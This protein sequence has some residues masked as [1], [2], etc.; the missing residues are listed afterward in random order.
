MASPPT[1]PPHEPTAT[2]A[3]L[4]GDVIQSRKH[5]DQI[6]LLETL[7]GLLERVNSV[8]ALRQPLAMTTGDGFQGFSTTLEDALR[9]TT[10]LHLAC[11]P[12]LDLRL[13]L[14]WG[15]IVIRDAVQVPVGQSGQAWWRARDAIELVASQVAKQKWP[16]S[17]RTWFIGDTP[18]RTAATNA[19]LICRDQILA[20]M[21]PS[22]R[23][24]AWGLFQS[25]R[26]ITL[27][28]DLAMTQPQISKHQKENGPAALFQAHAALED[29]LR[30]EATR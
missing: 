9:V 6:L 26:Q 19:F 1:S 29:G 23:R 14:G 13:G 4:I 27:A 10:L 16:R 8:Q 17:L 30:D 24:I 3:A 2:G 25:E 15:E 18:P 28:E 20:Q 21:D 11:P 7:E 12:E 5:P 22:V